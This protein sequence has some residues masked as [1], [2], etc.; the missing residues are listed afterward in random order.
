MDFF[1]V[2]I[3]QDVY[4]CDLENPIRVILEDHDSPRATSYSRI[5]K[6]EKETLRFIVLLFVV[7]VP[8]DLVELKDAKLV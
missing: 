8:I 2:R 6:L 7:F 5:F 1:S 4:H 3:L